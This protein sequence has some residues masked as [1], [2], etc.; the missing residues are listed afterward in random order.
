MLPGATLAVVLVTKHDPVDAGLLVLPGRVGHTAVAAGVLV[1]NGVHLV[2]LRDD[3]RDQEV[4]GDVL[5][6]TL[7]KWMLS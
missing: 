3:G 4:I 7:M 2:V 6:V 5:Q 1:L